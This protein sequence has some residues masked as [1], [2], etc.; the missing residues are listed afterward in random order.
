MNEWL[1]DYPCKQTLINSICVENFFTVDRF[2]KFEVDHCMPK[3]YAGLYHFDSHYVTI[4]PYAIEESNAERFIN[5]IFHEIGHSTSLHT[6]RWNRLTDN[7]PTMLISEVSKLEEQ[8]AETVAIAMTLICFNTTEGVNTKEFAKYL[9]KNNSRYRLPWE[10]VTL[11][12][13]S[14]VVPRKFDV[15]KKWLVTLK[16]FMINNNIILIKEGVFNGER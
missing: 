16:K 11:A 4:L 9:I 14:I 1:V 7:V 2:P 15:A 6:N 8:I 12:V 5:L 13:E 3:K 10:E